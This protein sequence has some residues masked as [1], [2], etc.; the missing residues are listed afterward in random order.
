MFKTFTFGIFLGFAASAAALYFFPVVD[1]GRERSI[2]SVQANGGNLEAFHVNLPADR[3]F[4]GGGDT[5]IP[6]DARWPIDIDIGDAQAELFK[7]RNAEERVIG[8]ASRLSAG[9]DR[10][11]VEWVLH[12]PARGSLYVAVDPTS[13]EVSGRSGLLRAGTREFSDLQGAVT[14]RY[15][16]GSEGAGRLELVAALMGRLAP[17]LTEAEEGS[18]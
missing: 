10:P 5:A 17:D 18:L 12:M 13:S 2:T 11:F 16:A 9:G 4:A 3:I 7:V 8:V 1:Q 6:A 15:V 14:E